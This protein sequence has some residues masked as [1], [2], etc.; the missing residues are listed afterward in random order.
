MPPILFYLLSFLV[1]AS[2]MFMIFQ[3][4][5]LTAAFS[6]VICFIGLAGLYAMLMAPLLAI[7]QVLVYAGAIMALVVFV[8]MLLNV[9]DEDLP[10]E[11]HLNRGTGIAL[12]VLAPVFYIL[13]RA[14]GKYPSETPADSAMAPGFGN[15]APVGL[16]LFN[17]FAFQFEIISLL[18]TVAVVGVVVLAKR[19]I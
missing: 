4:H 7:L 18:L 9:G 10:E 8:I 15:T 1:I 2:A 11:K 5:P 6:L 14:I 19:R 13:V 16:H 3:R 17:H 12:L